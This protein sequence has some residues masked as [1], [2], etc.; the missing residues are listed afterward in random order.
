LQMVLNQS[1]KENKV[2]ILYIDWDYWRNLAVPELVRI[3]LGH[4]HSHGN[5]TWGIR[6]RISTRYWLMI[7]ENCSLNTVHI[8][9]LLIIR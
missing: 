1:I 6:C 3:D 4:Y 9:S 8:C 5:V 2:L 7:T